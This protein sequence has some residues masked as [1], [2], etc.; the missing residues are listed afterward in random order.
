MRKLLMILVIAF[1]CD[2]L[3]AQPFTWMNG[4]SSLNIPGQYGTQGI[5]STANTPGARRGAGYCR[6]KSGNFWL[7][8]GEGYDHIGNFDK[9][10]DLWKYNPLTNEWTWVKG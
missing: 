9:L 6:D 10:N 8:G 2:I 7:F 5:P 4:T 3:N 1:T